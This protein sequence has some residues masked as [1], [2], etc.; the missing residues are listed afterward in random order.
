MVCFILPLPPKAK[1]S[2]PP[3]DYEK[4]GH[5]KQLQRAVSRKKR[6][7][8]RR[9]KAVH[10]LAQLHEKVANQRKDYA[11]KLSRQLVNRYGLIAFENLNVQGMIKN[12]HLAKSITDAGWNHLDSPR[13]RLK[14]PVV[15]LFW[16]ILAIHLRFVQTAVKL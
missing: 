8:N 4:E 5:L 15:W 6:G 7:S 2:R 14:A 16:L 10:V 12:C 9:K 13:T 11:H 1:R 3:S